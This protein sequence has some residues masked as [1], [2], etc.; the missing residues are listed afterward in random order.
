MGQT[1][2]VP[3]SPRAGR[4]VARVLENP[5]LGLEPT[6][7]FDVEI[8][9]EPFELDGQRQEASVRLDF[10]RLPVSDWRDLE[11]REYRFP[12]NPEEGYIDGSVL[13]RGVHHPADATRIRFGRI[14]GRTISAELEIAFEL[15]LGAPAEPRRGQVCWTIPLAVDEDAR[16]GEA[17]SPLLAS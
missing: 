7:F 3:F 9:L 17:M 15:Q 12:V 6:P 4:M 16:S 2:A 13:L 10:I 11:G 1:S 8:P 5:H 14:E